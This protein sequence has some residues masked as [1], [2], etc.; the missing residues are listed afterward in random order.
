MSGCGPCSGGKGTIRRSDGEVGFSAM[1][2]G[3]V[4]FPPS[5]RLLER[6]LDN[7]T[8]VPFSPTKK[9]MRAIQE[10]RDVRTAVREYHEELGATRASEWTQVGSGATGKKVGGTE[11]VS[12]VADGVSAT[13]DAD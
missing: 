2:G 8:P 6:W 11:A 7:Q 10:G 1:G 13:V 9:Y 3:R 4:A 12:M 5:A